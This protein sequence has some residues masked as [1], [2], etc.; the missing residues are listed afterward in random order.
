MTYPNR[1][2][3]WIDEVVIHILI[4]LFLVICMGVLWIIC[5]IIGIEFADGF[6]MVSEAACNTEAWC[7]M[8][9]KANK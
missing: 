3:P 1:E 8:I 9:S 2:E 7:Q 4:T 5:W 6:R